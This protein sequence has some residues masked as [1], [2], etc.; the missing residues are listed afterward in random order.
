MQDKTVFITGA[1]S[2]IGQETA[3]ALAKKGAAIVFTSRDPEKGKLVQKELI[4]RSNNKNIHL[5]FCDLASFDS[6]RNCCD[7][8]KFKFDKLNILVNNAAV[9]DFK[10]RESQ[11][12]IENTLATNYLAPF[13]MTN[14]LMD[15]IKKSSPARIINLT[16]GLHYGTI[17]FKDI[18]FKRKFG[19]FKAYKQSKLADILFTRLLAK[20]LD[21][22]GITVN[23]VHPGMVNTNLARDAGWFMRG[24][25]KIIGKPAHKGALTS[26]YLATSPEV[27]NITGEYFYKCRVRKSSKQS[28]DM[29]LAEKLWKVSEEYTGSKFKI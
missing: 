19:G 26:I 13:L 18:E 12:G 27:E 23:C 11:D 10:R 25:F 24:I 3:L 21:G 28:Y 6:I 8:F 9:W 20:K 5:I 16:S 29:E 2:G 22:T 17:N 14:M 1:T 4:K 15:T 7:E